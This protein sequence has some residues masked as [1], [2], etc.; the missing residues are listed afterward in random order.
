MV[1]FDE[2]DRTAT[3]PIKIRK[4]IMK[5][6]DLVLYYSSI[7]PRADG[8]DDVGLILGYAEVLNEYGDDADDIKVQW[9]SNDEISY[10]SEA[11]LTH[12]PY[13]EVVS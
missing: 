13:L 11:G 5:V 12:N 8:P 2:G 9:I 7:N 10:Y 1:S 6:G 4:A 3:I